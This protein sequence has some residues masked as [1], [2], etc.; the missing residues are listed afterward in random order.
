LGKARRGLLHFAVER[1][2]F[3]KEEETKRFA[4]EESV[5]TELATVLGVDGFAERDYR[6]DPDLAVPQSLVVFV[7]R[8]VEFSHKIQ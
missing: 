5:D 1:K 8:T 7:Q 6:I 2:K 3:R 4:E